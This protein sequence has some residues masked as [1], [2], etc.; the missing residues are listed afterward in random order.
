ME[1]AD[2]RDSPGPLGPAPIPQHNVAARLLSDDFS[3]VYLPF[4]F[5]SPS[6]APRPSVASA[7]RPPALGLA[8][9]SLAALSGGDCSRQT[10]N[11]GPVAPP[12]IPQILALALTIAPRWAA[13]SESRDSGVDP[14]D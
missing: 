10:G 7:W 11:R 13:G 1:S 6:A 12:R 14:A 9:P 2:Y 3:L 4:V 8:L 5:R